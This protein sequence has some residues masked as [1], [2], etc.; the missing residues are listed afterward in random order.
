MNN[1]PIFCIEDCPHM[2]EESPDY[3]IPTHSLLP[4]ECN[5]YKVFIYHGPHWPKLIR[6]SK[7]DMKTETVSL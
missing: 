4:H 7:C 2:V 1:D 6:Y 3:D 5:K